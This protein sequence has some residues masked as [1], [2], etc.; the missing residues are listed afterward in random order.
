MTHLIIPSMQFFSAFKRMVQAYREA[1]EDRY[2]DVASDP[3]GFFEYLDRLSESASGVASGPGLVPDSTF[4]LTDDKSI[5][6]VVRIRHALSESLLVEGG[7]IGYDI[8]PDFRAKGYGH[9]IFELA[10]VEARKLGIER[11]LVTCDHDNDASM[12]IIEKGGG[13]FE[14]ESISPRTGKRVRRYWIEL[15]DCQQNV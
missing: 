11:A 14:N 2:Q 3:A 1:G 8:N 5:I 10:L 4:W 7:H 15:A 9:R 6:G 13:V 12:R